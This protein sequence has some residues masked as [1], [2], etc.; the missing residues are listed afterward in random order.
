MNKKL[1]W[2]PV[3]L[4][5]GITAKAFS[6]QQDSLSNA[7]V[8]Y[9]SKALSVNK[10]KAKQV[11]DILDKYK[12]DAKA[13]ADNGTLSEE[14]KRLRI[15]LLIHDKVLALRVLLSAKQLQKIV[16]TSEINN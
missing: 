4:T 5:A 12:G 10:T 6:Q 11:A 1:F 3:I 15:N 2:I 8:T 7:Q 9:Y 13:I 16:P 14:I